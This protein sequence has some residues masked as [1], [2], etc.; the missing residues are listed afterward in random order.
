MRIAL[1]VLAT[2]GAMLPWL[3]GAPPI[4][5]CS[6]GPDYDPVTASDVIV[7]GRITGWSVIKNATTWGPK[8]NDPVPADDPNYYGLAT[9]IRL[10]MAVDQVYKGRAPERLDMVADNTFVR[11]GNHDY[12]VGSDGSCGAFD[13]DPT[14]QYWI[15]GLS[16]D[17]FGRHRPGLPSVFLRG[18]DEPVGVAYDYYDAYL[19][20]RLGPAALPI[21]GGP[22]GT[23][24][25]SDTKFM[26]I[27]V[28]L[29]LIAASAVIVQRTTFRSHHG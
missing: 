1:L 4:H 28:G 24:G 21:T 20:S 13:W 23:T 27:A 6:V 17:E 26:S 11:L 25:A 8:A 12:W 16:N 7:G 9:P 2:A 29:A 18:L 14:G 22:P 19:E 3:I 10:T 5:A 15:L